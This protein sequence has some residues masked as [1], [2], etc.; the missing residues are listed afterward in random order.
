MLLRGN[1]QTERW[2]FHWYGLFFLSFFRCYSSS[3]SFFNI[4]IH[5]FF[6][7]F[8]I[9]SSH[10]QLWSFLPYCWLDLLCKT[11]FNGN[12]NVILSWAIMLAIYSRFKILWFFWQ[13][14]R[15][16]VIKDWMTAFEKTWAE[17]LTR[18]VSDHFLILLG[19]QGGGGGIRGPSPFRFENDWLDSPIL[20][21]LVGGLQMIWMAGLVTLG[22]TKRVEGRG[23]CSSGIRKFLGT[24]F[25]N[26]IDDR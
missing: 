2:N 25:Q 4:F 17:R 10:S 16:L 18:P 3:S 1:R 26:A 22:E 14:N 8:S 6:F 5:L 11:K 23:Y 24:L 21:P 20:L 13:S 9:L 15:F 12:G 7:G 19:Y